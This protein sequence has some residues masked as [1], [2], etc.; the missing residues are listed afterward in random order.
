MS[1][2]WSQRNT[3]NR[4]HIFADA[5]A[6]NSGHSLTERGPIGPPGL[7]G[8]NGIDGV[9]GAPGLDG[10]AD[11]MV[12]D[13]IANAPT[14]YGATNFQ[15]QIYGSTDMLADHRCIRS[16]G[17]SPHV[18]NGNHHVRS[19]ALL[20]K[21]GVYRFT[22]NSRNVHQDEYSF[23]FDVNHNHVIG[24]MNGNEDPW[25][26]WAYTPSAT[27]SYTY[28]ITNNTNFYFIERT[29]VTNSSYVA[30]RPQM[31]FERLGHV[32]ESGTDDTLQGYWGVPVI[33]TQTINGGL[34]WGQAYQPP[35]AT[36]HPLQL[37][38]N[39]F[40]V[41]EVAAENGLSAAQQPFG[42]IHRIKRFL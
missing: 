34:Y 14:A 10:N 19:I 32:E 6:D 16:Q 4:T 15:Y 31:I 40:S 8:L 18:Y 17:T 26:P 3:Y 42:W 25:T 37:V 24:Y 22:F 11:F 39:P 23:G 36:H 30:Q 29:N 20:F 27:V 21:P 2:Y 12:L 28:M 38:N 5:S 1:R 13:A 41:V 35:P 33:N 9:D 7:N